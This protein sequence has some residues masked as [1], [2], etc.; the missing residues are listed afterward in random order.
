MKNRLTRFKELGFILTLSFLTLWLP[1]GLFPLAGNP[2][3]AKLS[4]D[5]PIGISGK[6]RAAGAATNCP[7]FSFASHINLA[8]NPSFEIVGPKG[9]TTIWLPGNPIP[10]PS[11]ARDWLMHS[12]NPP[13]D[14]VASKL[15]STTVPGPGGSRMLRFRAGGNEGGLLQLLPS[16]PAKLMFSAWVY[17]RRGRVQ[18]AASA[19]AD[20]PAAWSTKH[21]EWEQLRVC[22]DGTIPTGAFSIYNQDPQ[23]GEFFVDRVEI[24]QTL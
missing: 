4:T 8:R 9:S 21:N 6:T 14:P 18:L 15:V 22:T 5:L 13:G 19:G 24:R 20:V 16:A 10:P 1:G 11:A 23:G 7:P 17:V 2:A 3:P 12:S